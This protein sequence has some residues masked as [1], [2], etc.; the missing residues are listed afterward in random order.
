MRRTASRQGACSF[1]SI[2]GPRY[3][4]RPQSSFPLAP[5][6]RIRGNIQTVSSPA[7]PSAMSKPRWPV[8][9]RCRGFFSFFILF[10]F[11]L[12]FCNWPSITN[13]NCHSVVLKSQIKK[14]KNSTKDRRAL[15]FTV[16]AGGKKPNATSGKM[17]MLISEAE[18]PG[19]GSEILAPRFA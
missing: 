12:Q 19:F 1:I 10:N 13:K 2:R 9:K 7:D 4:R 16:F 8:V 3:W 18:L 17:E 11:F 6:L 15:L 14:R 5:Q